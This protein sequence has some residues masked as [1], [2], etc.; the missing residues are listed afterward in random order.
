MQFFLSSFFGKC[1]HKRDFC[2]VSRWVHQLFAGQNF[3][4]RQKWRVYRYG[5]VSIKKKKKDEEEN[6]ELKPGRGREGRWWAGLGFFFF[7][8][9]FFFLQKVPF[10]YFMSVGIIRK[11][12]SKL[13]FVVSA[14]RILL[15]SELT[16]AYRKCRINTDF[17][18]DIGIRLT[19]IS[20]ST[21]FSPTAAAPKT[22]CQKRSL[23]QT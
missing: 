15:A 12:F 18:T 17:G 22:V 5:V 2:R 10:R 19:S 16:V 9:F 14:A 4:V 7:F 1:Q 6:P 20:N 11:R 23:Y 8:F 3:K 21:S 13:L